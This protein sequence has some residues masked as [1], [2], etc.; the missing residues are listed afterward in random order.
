[1][2]TRPIHFGLTG[3]GG[4]A[5][6]A[7]DRLLEASTRADAPAQ[8][9]AVVEPHVDRFRG[10]AEQLGAR[11]VRVVGTYRELL[12]MP[13]DALWLP[14]PIDLHR[15]Y[16]ERALAAGKAVLCEKPAAGS[17]DDVDAMIACRDAHDG[18]VLVGFQDVYQPCVAELKRRLLSGEFGAPLFASVIGCW[19]RDVHYFSRNEWV[20]KF[21]RDGRWVMD[22]PANNALAHFLHLALFLLGP[23]PSEATYPSDVAAELYRVNAI[24]SFD[25]CALRYTVA[26]G[27]PLT[28]AL[29]H[30]CEES[31][32]PEVTI[33]CER[34]QIRYLHGRHA[35][36]RIG[37]GVE[38]FPLDTNPY[39][40]LL[41]SFRRHV[42]HRESRRPDDGAI[43]VAAVATLESARAHVV[44]VNAAAEATEIIDVPPQFVTEVQL[45]A[46]RPRARAIRGIVPA[47]LS[48]ASPGTLTELPSD[49]G[50]LHESAAFTWTRRAGRLRIPAN[51]SHFSGPRCGSRSKRHDAIAVR[52][53][54][55]TGDAG[56]VATVIEH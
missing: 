22:S 13:I 27:V 8:L 10:Q 15:P 34:G 46:Q 56:S 32:E 4:F 21:S 12:D 30:A 38:I 3:L 25:T 9:V 26:G 2:N 33:Q 48:L 47:M 44:A 37:T 20:G 7:C 52:H 16:T 54:V 1:L 24:E 39:M 41:A 18:Q 35:E 6:Y 14:L 36:L 53:P 17:V 45:A 29:S 43:D 5:G 31:I 40:R 50:L 28:V 11:G 42:L 55:E 23:R 51:Y 19:P 49:S